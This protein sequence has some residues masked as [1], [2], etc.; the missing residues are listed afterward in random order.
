MIGNENTIIV[1]ST[2]A[3]VRPYI[4]LTGF[5]SFMKSQGFSPLYTIALTQCCRGVR[6]SM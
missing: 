6:R 2:V 5:K 4:K 3:S 1:I